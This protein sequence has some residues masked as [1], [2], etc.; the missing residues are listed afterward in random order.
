MQQV[1]FELV[2]PPRVHELDRDS[3]D[4]AALLPDHLA[5][6]ERGQQHKVVLP[7]PRDGQAVVHVGDEGVDAA[8]QPMLCIV[9]SAAAVILALLVL[10]ALLS[11]REQRHRRLLLPLLL[12]ARLEDLAL[13]GG[14]LRLGQARLQPFDP[15][16]QHREPLNAPGPAGSSRASP[17]FSI[18]STIS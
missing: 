15:A 5:D 7:Q 6:V 4:L 3:P 16:V 8:E 18:M 12:V 2:V 14:I 1:V 13:L 17:C 9:H 11:S 10:A